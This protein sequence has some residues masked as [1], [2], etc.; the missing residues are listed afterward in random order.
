MD[1]VKEKGIF[2]RS[3]NYLDGVFKFKYLLITE[4]TAKNL[5]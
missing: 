5:L 3:S 4:K 2:F 1:I